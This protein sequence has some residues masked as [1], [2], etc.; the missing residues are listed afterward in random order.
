MKFFQKVL[1]CFLAFSLIVSNFPLQVIANSAVNHSFL[2]RTY[3]E[4]ALASKR[5]DSAVLNHSFSYDDLKL[6]Q[7]K[8][9]LLFSLPGCSFNIRENTPKLPRYDKIIYLEKNWRLV[10]AETLQLKTL[11]FPLPNVPLEM[12]PPW[13][14]YEL[15]SKQVKVHNPAPNALSIQQFPNENFTIQ[16]CYTADRPFI[17]VKLSPIYLRQGKWYFTKNIRIKLNYTFLSE[18]ELPNVRIKDAIIITPDILAEEAIQLKILQEKQGYQVSVLKLSSVAN[19][20]LAERPK[21]KYYTGYSDF[22]PDKIPLLKNYDDTNARRII[23]FLQQK[24]QKDEVDYVTILGDSKLIPPSYYVFT[25]YSQYADNWVPTDQFYASPFNKG[26]DFK[27][28]IKLGRI[29]VRNRKEMQVYLT[30]LKKYH[31]NLNSEWFSQAAVLGGD[32]FYGEYMGELIT[33]NTINR[34]RLKGFQI[35]KYFRTEDKFETSAVLDLLKNKDKGVIYH[36][37]H[38]SG[39][40]LHLEPGEIDAEEGL[41]LPAKDKLPLFVSIACMNGAWDTQEFPDLFQTPVQSELPT[42]FSQGLVLGEGGAI[43][44]I[45]GSR[46]NYGVVDYEDENGLLELEE[47]A[48][49]MA[50]VLDDFCKHVSQ[51]SGSLGTASQKTLLSYLESE[52]GY[53]Y[54]P[55]G[56]TFFGFTLMGDPTLLMPELKESKSFTAPKLSY[57]ESFKKNTDKMPLCPI[58]DGF[59]LNINS[60]SPAFKYV[61]AQYGVESKARKDAGTLNNQSLRGM[62]TFFNPT[63]K[64]N[65]TLR[66]ETDDFKENRFVFW[67]KYNHDLVMSAD[68]ALSHLRPG[69]RQN[70]GFTLIND[71][72]EDESN[73]TATIQYGEKVKEYKISEFPATSK[74]FLWLE[75]EHNE[76]EAIEIKASTNEIRN[77]KNREDNVSTLM[78]KSPKERFYRVGYWSESQLLRGE[79]DPSELIEKLNH[80]MSQTQVPVEF[81]PIYSKFDQADQSYMHDRLKPDLI[82]IDSPEAFDMNFSPIYRLLSNYLENGGKILCLG[83]VGKNNAG[84]D[85]SQMQSLFG[86]PVEAKF[87]ANAIKDETTSLHADPSMMDHMSQK[88][89]QLPLEKVFLPLED[90]SV[91]E[92]C[93]E[94]KLLAQCKEEQVVVMDN[95]SVVFVNATLDWSKIDEDNHLMSF[96]SDLV[97]YA[98]QKPVYPFI[99]RFSLTPTVGAKNQEASLELQINYFGAVASDALSL[100]ISGDPLWEQMI[101]IP[102][103]HPY[104]KR[105][106]S[107][108]LPLQKMSGTKTIQAVLRISGEKQE[109]KI[110]SSYTQPY[111]IQANGEPDEAPSLSLKGDKILSTAES[112]YVIEGK[113]HP[114][115]KVKLNEQDTAINADGSFQVLWPLH[116]GVNNIKLSASQGSLSSED[117]LSI[118][119]LQKVSI[120]LPINQAQCLV[121][122]VEKTLDEPAIIIKGST[123]VPLRFIAESFKMEVEWIAKE[124]KIILRQRDLEIILWVGN[125]KALINNREVTLSSPPFIGKSKRTLLP[126]RFIAE[127]MKAEVV[128]DKDHQE[129]RIALGVPYEKTENITSCSIE[130]PKEAV[131]P[132]ILDES[133]PDHLSFP[134]CIDQWGDQLYA[135]TNQN[136]MVY[137]LDMELLS[138]RPLPASFWQKGSVSDKLGSLSMANRALMRVNE[139][140]LVLLCGSDSVLIYDRESLEL[141]HTIHNSELGLSLNMSSKWRILYDMELTDNN[142]LYLV[143]AYSILV[144]DLHLMELKSLL[145]PVFNIDLVVGKDKL[146]V[147]HLFEIGIYSLQGKPLGIIEPADYLFPYTIAY[148]SDSLLL[149]Y[150]PIDE[151]LVLLNEEGDIEKRVSVSSRVGYAIERVVKIEQGIYFVS[152]FLSNKIPYTQSRLFRMDNKFKTIFETHKDLSKTLRGMTRLIPDPI[153]LWTSADNTRYVNSYNPRNPLSLIRLDPENIEHEEIPIEIDYEGGSFFDQIIAMGFCD[154]GQVAVMIVNVISMEHKLF[155]YDLEEEDSTVVTLQTEREM[156]LFPTFTF[157]DENIMVHDLFSGDIVY[158]DRDSGKESDFIPLLPKA[159]LMNVGQLFSRKDRLYVW[160]NEARTMGYFS[161][162]KSWNKMMDLGNLLPSSAQGIHAIDVDQ[163]G[164]IFALDSLSGSL[165]RI[166]DQE[167]QLWGKN[168]EDFSLPALISAGK[169]SLLVHDFGNQRLLEVSKTPE[170]TSEKKTPSMSVYIEN[171]EFQFYKDKKM[172]IPVSLQLFH[173]SDPVRCSTLPQYL[174]LK[175]F[176]KD[177]ASQVF[178]LELD[179]EQIKS[180]TEEKLQFTS[181]ELTET[182]KLTFEPL[183][184]SLYGH[185]GSPYL[186]YPGGYFLS[187]TALSIDKGIIRMGEDALKS[188]GF[189]VVHSKDEVQ[190]NYM[191]KVFILVPG[192]N[193]GWM[194]I[195][196]SR[197]PI[198]VL[199]KVTRDSHQ[200][201]YPINTLFDMI[202]RP[203]QVQG[204]KIIFAE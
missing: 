75:V 138:T 191:G 40:G 71:G 45:G 121:N 22:K 141:I 57:K 16:T 193:Q 162:D 31:S 149:A 65:L 142:L 143:D 13:L 112:H 39:S 29:P 19:M 133:L 10:S 181:N 69:D 104:E 5:I 190:L 203:V 153:Q 91:S 6:S 51:G 67:S 79:N 155:I 7:G 96:L 108:K 178:Y 76:D 197:M 34:D 124:Q 179:L 63:W 74:Q 43:A 183:Q 60:N 99:Q 156:Y 118:E 161:K 97:Q 53:D 49:Y 136:I 62:E 123:F 164:V 198:D 119:R 54:Q 25:G 44:Y 152:I 175:G 135:I 115:A 18:T 11:E 188:Y 140:Y 139:E 163:E 148:Y 27:L 109:N 144:F 145:G 189:D 23:S 184:E 33:S 187:K 8:N 41:K 196:Q 21:S 89:Y 4:Y 95:G 134:L 165:I 59:R 36:I 100:E 42:S 87:E 64:S 182:L 35:E 167:V 66:I 58:D 173:A 185:I 131:L 127:G 107:I 103:L 102:A 12:V 150:D 83:S 177:K 113:T 47:H 154:L 94:G 78:L 168:P 160:D 70:L 101:A 116:P 46:N 26:D 170:E 81:F 157:D 9:G 88:E 176:S 38:G 14:P 28:Q 169:N 37:G 201:T 158:F 98:S 200:Y 120:S 147:S 114:E 61:I 146:Y 194:I 56:N 77:E 137:S 110:I 117:Q 204:T 166:Q 92:W 68:S 159:K 151:I 55:G 2:P 24:L 192:S 106:H 186:H 85:I 93:P 32:P 15:A 125:T 171:T 72:I 129:V 90:S 126:L 84:I 105:T 80:S 1:F 132:R 199:Q 82:V 52:W 122:G 17:R 30:K 48:G 180:K 86:L 128:W 73:V 195:N 174:S 172:E 111:T 20:S 50:Y 202:M 130:D 3:T